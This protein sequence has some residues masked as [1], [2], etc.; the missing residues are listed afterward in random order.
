L[1]RP[2]K[3]HVAQ[4]QEHRASNVARQPSYS[5]HQPLT[6]AST[7]RPAGRG[8]ESWITAPFT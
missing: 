3:Y 4:R 5:T 8:H 6:H 1:Q 7:P 2:P